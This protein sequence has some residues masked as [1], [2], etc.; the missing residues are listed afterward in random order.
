MCWRGVVFTETHSSLMAGGDDADADR[1]A[2][3][4]AADVPGMIEP[5]LAPAAAGGSRQ[6]LQ[7]T[8]NCQNID[9]FKKWHIIVY[10]LHTAFSK[11]L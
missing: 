11:L 4:G 1:V 10:C 8:S 7:N 2:A 3:G 9:G 5:P 6:R